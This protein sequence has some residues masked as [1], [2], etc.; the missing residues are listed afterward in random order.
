[1]LARLPGC[2]APPSRHHHVDPEWLITQSKAAKP[3]PTDRPRWTGNPPVE[4]IEA[5]GTHDVR[6]PTTSL[7]A[8]QD[9]R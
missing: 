1:M 7:P 2:P 8:P 5:H 4:P 9:G 3:S 6:L